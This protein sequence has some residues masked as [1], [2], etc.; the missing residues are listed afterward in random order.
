[1]TQYTMSLQDQ[2]LDYAFQEIALTN[3]TALQ[4][5]CGSKVASDDEYGYFVPTSYLISF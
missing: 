3:R 1:M 2:A 4:L 5:A